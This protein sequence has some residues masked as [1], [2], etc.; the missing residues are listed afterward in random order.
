MIIYNRE[1]FNN[2][3]YFFLK[4]RGDKISLYY[5]VADTLTESRKKD[6]KKEFNK[7]QEKSLKQTIHKFLSSKKK[8]SK[9]EIE[10]ELNKVQKGE[11][12]ELIDSDGTMLNS[13]IPPLDA[14][15]H[16]RKT[17]DQTIGMSRV[18]NDPVTRGYRVY[19]GESEEKEG[20]VVNE[21][22]FSDAFGYEETKDKDYKETVKTLKQMGVENPIERTKQFGKLPKVKKKKGKLKQRLVE[23][24]K[25]DEVQRN[26][27]VKMVEDIIAKKSKGESDVVGRD[28]PVNKILLNNLKSIKKLAEKEGI[29]LSQLMNALK[30]HE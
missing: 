15:L 8:L 18:T 10:M 25:L 13:K 29:S 22:D 27:M 24:E 30:N 1:Y 20:E 11:I 14:T 9:K 7:K 28:Q 26:K 4:D 21:I 3:C 6:E 2:G 19:W 16:P 5:T 23:K 12:D 17:L